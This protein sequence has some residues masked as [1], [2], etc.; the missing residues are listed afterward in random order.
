MLK[1]VR[2]ERQ[3]PSERR[4]CPATLL[5]TRRVTRARDLTAD[6]IWA[7]LRRVAF[8]VAMPKKLATQFRTPRH[9]DRRVGISGSQT[10]D[11]PMETGM[12]LC[13]WPSGEIS[14][15]K[16]DS[17]REAVIALDEWGGA[18]PSWLVPLEHWMANFRWSE[19][20]GIEVIELG[21]Q[22]AK[23][24]SNAAQSKK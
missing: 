5:L 1:A 12:Y 18:D 4:L 13:R 15:V 17:R 6:L 11:H 8:E 7:I 23:A 24:L 20:E 16:A 10:E 21:E 9:K 19:T 22:T 3:A 14:V 2:A